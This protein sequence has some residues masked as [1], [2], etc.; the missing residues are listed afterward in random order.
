MQQQEFA[1]PAWDTVPRRAIAAEATIER[2]VQQREVAGSWLES[3]AQH[4]RGSHDSFQDEISRS[5]L[6]G[7]RQQTGFNPVS[8]S[9]LAP[10]PE[11]KSFKLEASHRIL[12]D[13]PS[14]HSKQWSRCIH[15]VPL[16]PFHVEYN[17]TTLERNSEWLI[18]GQD[19]R[20]CRTAAAAR[21]RAEEPQVTNMPAPRPVPS[22]QDTPA[23]QIISKP[24]FREAVAGCGSVDAESSH[25]GNCQIFTEILVCDSSD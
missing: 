23:L 5:L 13:R 17:P 9:T 14:T 25:Q 1:E 3:A 18:A 22:I 8:C 15:S 16:F 10:C 11:V 20:Q 21:R 2:N 6:M 7:E 19:P 24:F 4:L 12:K